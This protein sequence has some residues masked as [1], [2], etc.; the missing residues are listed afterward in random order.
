MAASSLTT[1]LREDIDDI[2]DT[3][4]EPD[5]LRGSTVL[6]TGAAG[7]LPSYVVRTLAALNDRFS[8]GIRVLALVRN[9]D[10]AVTALGADLLGRGDVELIVQDV[11]EPLTIQTRV[12]HIVHGASA[13]RPSLHAQDP[14]GT[15]RA[16]VVGTMNLL[17]LGVQR[18]AS[19]FALMSSAEV[20][21]SQPPDRQLIRESDY[22]GLDILNPRA[23][24]SE[25]KRA[26]ESICAA[27]SAQHGMH[28]TIARFGHVY[29]PGMALDDGRVQAEFAACVLDGR[30]IRL[31]SDGTATRTY[32][33][34]A[35]AV[36][37]LFTAML[38]GESTAYN[39]AD[40]RGLVSIR[41]LAEQFARARPAAGI[42]VAFGGSVAGR[43]YSQA[44]RSGLDA[45]RLAALGWEPHV[46]LA[47]GID[48]LLRHH[49][50]QLVHP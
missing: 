26:A 43:A 3:I 18:H 50:E 20:Y 9:A 38:A 47:A 42:T 39:I 14:V 1:V 27:Y 12:D 2:V 44:V 7:M 49:E 4:P 8:A 19:S 36:S 13:A 17:D 21:G 16:N 30:D 48:R 15:I 32:T 34:A 10:R 24:Y 29:G 35:D 25:G 46:D 31:N 5:A 23:C 6:V 37:G 40:S 28:V 41:E 45:S 33:Y 11:S 22:G